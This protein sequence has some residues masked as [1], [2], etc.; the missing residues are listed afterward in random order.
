MDSLP[1]N[2]EKSLVGEEMPR[3][4]ERRFVLRLLAHWRNLCGDRRYPSFADLDPAEIPDMW[5]NCFMLEIAGNDAVPIFRAMGE[6][7]SARSGGPLIDRPMVD[8]QEDTLIGVAISYISEVLE[9]SVPVSRGGEFIRPDGIKVLY[10]SI[11]LPM[12]DDGETISGILG[13]AN[14]RDIVFE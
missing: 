3:G 10:R 13:A 1:A 4:I 8:A 2:A 14:C 5:R 7:L 6:D 9:K 11:L 12:S